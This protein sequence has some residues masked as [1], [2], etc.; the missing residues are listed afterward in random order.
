MVLLEN[1]TQAWDK[2][3]YC[4]KKL[5]AL[6]SDKDNELEIITEEEYKKLTKGE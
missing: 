4:R 5:V 2:C 1:I 6:M 3:P